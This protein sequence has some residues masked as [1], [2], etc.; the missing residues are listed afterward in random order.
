M[1]LVSVFN[2]YCLE[3]E[4][5]LLTNALLFG[6]LYNSDK[7]LRDLLFNE[8]SMISPMI[9]HS[10][11]CFEPNLG[12]KRPVK[13]NNFTFLEAKVFSLNVQLCIFLT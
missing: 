9:V 2:F 13:Q 3:A 10:Q 1:L 5:F 11:P 7:W 8:D 12:K 4:I 6:G